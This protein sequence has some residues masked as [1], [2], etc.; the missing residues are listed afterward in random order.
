M[1]ANVIHDRLDDPLAAPVDELAATLAEPLRP[2]RAPRAEGE[3]AWRLVLTHDI[4]DV[5]L[6]WREGDA[7]TY[8]RSR[9]GKA[10][11]VASLGGGQT[12]GEV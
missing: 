2:W 9:Y 12:E 10:A 8:F 3:P 4:G 7:L 5:G 1:L 6:V 11:N